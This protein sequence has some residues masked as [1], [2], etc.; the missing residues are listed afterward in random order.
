THARVLVTPAT[1][2]GVA[3]TRSVLDWMGGLHTSMLPTTVV[4]LAHAVPDTALDE[5]KAVERLGVGGP[6]VVSIPYDRHLAAGGAI[7]TE[8]LGE[9]TREAAARLAAACMARANSGG[10][11]GRPRA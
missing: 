4:A 9:H 8:L 1:V 3:A 7:Q 10:Q 11:T 5:A 2:E 6:A